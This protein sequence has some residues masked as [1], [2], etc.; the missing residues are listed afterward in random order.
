MSL[1]DREAIPE[2]LLYGYRE[3][4]DMEADFEDDIDML[5][6]YC[7]VG[8]SGGKDLFEMHRLVQFSMKK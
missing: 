3:E 5:R 8:M 6:S 4:S 2:P 7:L 1:F